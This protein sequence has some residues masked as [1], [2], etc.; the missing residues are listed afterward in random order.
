VGEE[1]KVSMPHAIHDGFLKARYAARFKFAI[2]WDNRNGAGVESMDDLLRTLFPFW[3]KHYF[4]HKSY[5]KIDNRPVLFIRDIEKLIGQLGG[6]R[7]TAQAF[8]AFWSTARKAGFSDMVLLGQECASDMKRLRQFADVGCDASFASYWPNIPNAASPDRAVTLQMAFLEHR[9]RL[10]FLPDLPLLSM[11]WD[12][13]PL[14]SPSDSVRGRGFY[15]VPP[16]HFKKL[17]RRVKRFMDALPRDHIGRR[18]LLLDNWNG[19]GE[20]RYMAPC[21]QNGFGYLE[22]IREVFTNAKGPAGYL[23]PEEAGRGPY[24]GLYRAALKAEKEGS[25]TLDG[26]KGKEDGGQEKGK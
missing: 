24:D 18:V 12:R 14:L 9:V 2:L 20:G 1:V 4:K 15:R 26:A 3:M 21:R 16:E 17:C 7:L 23:L 5:L 10:N 22:A 25:K 19:W 13:R 11:G 8:A 6:P